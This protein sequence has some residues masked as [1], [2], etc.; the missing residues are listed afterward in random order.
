MTGNG[1]FDGDDDLQ[2]EI[3]AW[4]SMFD[5]LHEGEDAYSAA[6]VAVESAKKQAEAA[7][8]ED[9]QFIVAE[10]GDDFEFELPESA[11]AKTNVVRRISVHLDQDSSAADPLIP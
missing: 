8:S 7:P 2:A 4:D 5:S 6:D 11:V 10:V 1:P 3:D 9:G